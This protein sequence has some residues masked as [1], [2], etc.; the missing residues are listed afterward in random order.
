MK[1]DREMAQAYRD[2]WQA[3][4]EVENAQRQQT[5]LTQRWQTLNALLRM[6]AALGVQLPFAD[7]ASVFDDSGCCLQ[8][9]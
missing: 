6:A 5:S 3:V 8:N 9:R 1:L 7:F 4:A 2:R